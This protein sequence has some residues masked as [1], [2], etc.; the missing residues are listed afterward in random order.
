[1]YYR[2]RAIPWRL[3]I[4]SSDARLP[5]VEVP[6]TRAMGKVVQAHGDTTYVYDPASG[7]LDVSFHNEA[8]WS[9]S[10]E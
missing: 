9:G 3:R 8:S 10:R 7:H 2:S 6:L 5:V 1:M 4:T